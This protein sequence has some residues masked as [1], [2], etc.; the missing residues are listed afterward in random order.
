MD[1]RL[2]LSFVGLG[3]A[4]P[5]LSQSRGDEARN[6]Q[7]DYPGFQ[8]LTGDVGALRNERLLPFAQFKKQAASAGTLLLDARSET[9]F[10]EG[11]IKGA[12][13]LP[14]PDFNAESL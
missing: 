9:A 7:I 1:R 3:A 4:T 10:R 11:H 5:A 12:V 14:F 6:P 2:F 13:N 8:Q